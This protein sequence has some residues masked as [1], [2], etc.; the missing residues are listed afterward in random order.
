MKLRNFKKED[1][2]II[3]GWIRS[4]EELYK[5]SAD[6]FNKYPLTGDDIIENY[7]HRIENGRFYP[8]DRIHGVCRERVRNADR[9][10]ELYGY[11]VALHMIFC[12]SGT[13][14]SRYIARRFAEAAITS[15]QA[16]RK[17]PALRNN[18]GYRIMSGIINPFFTG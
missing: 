10:L 12:F 13:G 15:V 8:L 2:P 3:A 4:E 16:G 7:T 17:F 1:A 11:G 6:C 9:H 5:W 18:V 14:N